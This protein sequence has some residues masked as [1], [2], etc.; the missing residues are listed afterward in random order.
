[1]AGADVRDIRLL[2]YPALAARRRLPT[3][4]LDG[5]GQEHVRAGQPGLLQR[6]VQQLARRS[7][8]RFAATVLDIAGLLAHQHETG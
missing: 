1:M 8:E 6:S 3:E 4:M 7:D 2:V 5:I